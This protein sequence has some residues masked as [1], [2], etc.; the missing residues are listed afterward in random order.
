[1]YP[2]LLSNAGSIDTTETL[3]PSFAAVARDEEDAEDEMD[4]SE[5]DRTGTPA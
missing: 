2:K 1:M 3:S 5:T 4:P